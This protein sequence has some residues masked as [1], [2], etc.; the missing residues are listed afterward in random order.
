MIQAAIFDMDGLLIDSEP[1]WQLAER[2]VFTSIGVRVTDE[3]A[4]QTATMTTREVTKFWF[5]L[6]PWSGLRLD[7]VENAV[8][9]RV[10]ALVEE[11]G[12]E[13]QGVSTTLS[14]LASKGIKIGLST[15][16]PHQLIPVI[17]NKLGIASF[18]D[19]ISSSD[20]VIK[21]KPEPD[22]YL[23]TVNKLGVEATHC[24]AFEDSYSGML[25]ATRANI[26]TIVVPHPDKYQQD[27]SESH[28]KLQSLS[29]FNESHLVALMT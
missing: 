29:D 15:N 16:S 24:I 11:R 17:L 10:E 7:E 19:A 1:L 3:L 18:F 26:K 22:V 25:A 27:F 20:D 28:L 12:S 4:E 21:G 2:E 14:L 9:N 5:D 13:L 8:I 6:Y 23:S